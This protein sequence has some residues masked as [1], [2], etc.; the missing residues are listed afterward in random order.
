[1]SSIEHI[2]FSVYNFK[3]NSVSTSFLEMLYKEEKK[4]DVISPGTSW[5]P[6]LFVR[7]CSYFHNL[8]DFLR[9]LFFL[10]IQHWY[11][12]GGQNDQIT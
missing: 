11:K 2:P 8:T 6:Y 9:L 5:S 7:F 4:K 3:R 10:C 1:M 12:S